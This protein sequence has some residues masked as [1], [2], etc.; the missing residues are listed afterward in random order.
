M[1]RRTEQY[2]TSG[3]WLAL[4]NDAVAH[5]TAIQCLYQWTTG[6]AF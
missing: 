1:S 2:Y 3:S 5:Y 6:P 4:G